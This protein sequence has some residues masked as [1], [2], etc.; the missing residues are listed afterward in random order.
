MI[1]VWTNGVFDL[2]HV[3]HVSLLE[4]S[5]A[6]GDKLIVGLNSDAATARLKPGRPIY[7]YD[8]R[9]QML[10]ALESVD[11]VVPI[12]D[13]PREV[14]A[15]LRPDIVVKGRGY[16]PATMIEAETVAAYGGRIV[17]LPSDDAISTTNTLA[18]LRGL[19]DGSRVS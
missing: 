1:T 10:M 16:D 2:L 5:K 19:E 14:L 15:W 7:P 13:D 17:I 4:R 3:A 9:R 12:E 11:L 8:D 6:L 18:K